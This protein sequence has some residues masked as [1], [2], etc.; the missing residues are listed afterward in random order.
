VVW[1]RGIFKF[2]VFLC[3]FFIG[4]SRLPS[5]VIRSPDPLLYPIAPDLICSPMFSQCASPRSVHEI[6]NEISFAI[7]LL[8][9]LFCLL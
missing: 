3:L 4:D 1:C 2:Y 9:R 8:S 7:F 5:R 6:S